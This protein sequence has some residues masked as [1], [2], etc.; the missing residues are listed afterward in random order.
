M[1][2]KELVKVI[3]PIL[4][5]LLCG[6]VIMLERYGV[7]TEYVEKNNRVEKLSFSKE[8]QTK[9]E[10][11]ILTNRK[12]DMH[13]QIEEIT[14]FVL[15]SM[16]IGYDK[17]E[18]DAAY[19]IKT[20]EQYDTVVV[21]FQDWSVLGKNISK[22]CKWV[23]EGGRLMNVA[24]PNPDGSF[25]AIAQKFGIQNGGGSYAA[26][27][28]FHILDN[29]MVGAK[30]WSRYKFEDDIMTSLTVALDD[31]VKVYVE[32]YD[33]SVPLIWSREYGDGR[34]VFLNDF[35]I[36]KYQRAFISFAYSLL[37]DVCVYPVI[38]ASAFYLDDFPA[39]VPDGD[40]E[41]IK[42]DYSV[43]TATFYSTIWWPDVLDMEKEYGI[44]HTGLIIEQYSDEV[45]A[46]FIR[47]KAISQMVTY[48]NM[49]LNNGGELGFH[50]YNHMPLCLK[51][52]D[53][54][55]KLGSY[56]L[57]KKPED[58]KA[59]V[60]ELEEFSE[61]LFPQASFHVYVPP[62]NIISDTGVSLL[63]DACKDINIIASIYLRDSENMAYVQEFNTDE[64]GTV[65]TP[66]IVSG[67]NLDDYQKLSAFSELNFHYVQSHFMHPDDILDEDRGAA[68]GWEKLKKDFKGYLGW[69]KK[70]VPDIRNVTGSEMGEAV[71]KYDNVN[72]KKTYKDDVLSVEIGGFSDSAEFF[73]RIN[74]KDV[75]KT[76]GCTVKK[77]AENLY[78]V[79]ADTDNIKVYLR[80]GSD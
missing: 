21:A 41:Y 66:R 12:E 14:E 50:G 70:S 75:D 54:N 25:L 45:K 44:K 78:A 59:A 76:E 57:W 22:L 42:R 8:V 65:N 32:S 15:D 31:K 80:G 47:N 48:G 77:V 55:R 72:L 62:S 61:S 34:F 3:I 16:K 28:G 79:S 9:K 58:M 19:L 30:E 74:G 2:A 26:I 40:S 10:C 73:L 71:L 39:P 38:N 4:A 11:L 23:S 51:G 36:E 27:N 67:C 17:E 63:K 13:T 35:I 52:I 46:P 53:D 56:K 68:L 20:V 37:E 29:C 64:D 43:D 18:A 1:K 60:R 33:G 49:L 7:T 5:L 24:T 69:L 6:I